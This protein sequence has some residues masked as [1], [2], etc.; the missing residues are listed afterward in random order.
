MSSHPHYAGHYGATQH[1]EHPQARKPQGH[2]GSPRNVF[3]VA[4]V[5]LLTLLC[6][7]P[8]WNAIALLMDYNYTYWVGFGVPLWMIFLCVSII[9]LY[10]ATI[11]IFFSHARPQV[12]TEQTIMMIANIFITL[13]GLVLMLVSLPLS[14]QSIETYNNLMHRC[15]YSEQ[16]HRVYEY[17][18]VL[19]N[20]RSL[21]ACAD[22]YSIEECPG[23][24]DAKPYA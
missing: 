10:A 21:P 17:S 5:I 16:T 9:I 11:S 20:I 8:M 18:Q 7:V 14:R 19:Q 3:I 4:G 23:Y 13:L 6:L 24:E 2:T 15:D 12:Q 1:F 22:K